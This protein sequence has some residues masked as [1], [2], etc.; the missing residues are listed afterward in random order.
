MENAKLKGEVERMRDRIRSLETASETYEHR[1]DNERKHAAEQRKTLQEKYDQ[2]VKARKELEEKLRA[3]DIKNRRPRSQNRG[4]G[5]AQGTLHA[6]AR[7]SGPPKPYNNNNSNS[8]NNSCIPPFRLDTAGVNVQRRK[9]FLPVPSRPST[10][11]RPPCTRE[12]GSSSSTLVSS[13]HSTF[14]RASEDTQESFSSVETLSGRSASPNSPR[15][16]KPSSPTPLMVPPPQPKAENTTATL[17]FY[18]D[19]VSHLKKPSWA[20]VARSASNIS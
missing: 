19:Q 3:M 11:I 16:M 9:S 4:R 12:P 13:I 1:I 10:P 7:E 20:N 8:N 18:R 6:N 17:G 14:S 15:T 5:R 2:E